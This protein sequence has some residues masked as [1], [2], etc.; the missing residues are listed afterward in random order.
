MPSDKV[1]HLGANG[2]GIGDAVILTAIARQAK[3]QRPELRVFVSCNAR[4]LIRG[5]QF[6]DEVLPHGVLDPSWPGLH[7]MKSL[8]SRHIVQ[9]MCETVGLEPPPR[10]DCRCWID[11]TDDDFSTTLDLPERYLSLHV[12]PGDWN[13]LRMWTPGRWAQV[14]EGLGVPVV[15]VGGAGDPLVAGVIDRRGEPI[16]RSAAIISDA[17]AHMGI[18]SSMMLVASG[19]GTPSFTV[20]GGREDPTYLKNPLDTPFSGFPEHGCAPCYRF[21]CDYQQAAS[22]P[23]CMEMITATTV[24]N[25]VKGYLWDTES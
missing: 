1:L 5:N 19:V 13:L 22:S 16:R 21:Q 14:V 11:L 10:D 24:I 25:E 23:P 7:D 20:Y 9:Y 12:K 4:D 2:P 17:L 3:L 18:V 15:Q 6:I 8:G